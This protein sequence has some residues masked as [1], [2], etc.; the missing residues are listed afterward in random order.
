M[1]RL[2]LTYYYH[3]ANTE[4]VD[5]VNEKNDIVGSADVTT[6]HDQKLTHRVV[7]VFVFDA[8]GVLYLQSGNKYGRLDIS[9]GGHVQK[10]E[11]YE[12]AAKREM[13]EELGLIIPIKHIST[14]LPKDARLSHYWTIFTAT[15][16]R[17]WEFKKTDEVISLEKMT[18]IK[19]KDMMQAQPDAFTHGFINAMT[20]LIRVQGL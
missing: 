15:A 5:I 11:M 16:P 13:F 2:Q 17:D 7:G 8:D 20:E 6:T 10:G 1:V 9:V 4:L 14:F 12:D 18:L 3:M 19:V